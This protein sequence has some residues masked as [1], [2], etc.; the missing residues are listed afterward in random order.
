M[1]LAS[2]STESPLCQVDFTSNHNYEK[3][4]SS[5][6]YTLSDREQERQPSGASGIGVSLRWGLAL[7]AG[8]GGA[9]LAERPGR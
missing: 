6:P 8:M 3:S 9:M 1:I 4:L 5:R 2:R 7:C